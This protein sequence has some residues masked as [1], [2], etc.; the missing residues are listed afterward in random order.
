MIDAT[1]L[2]R[3]TPEDQQIASC[4]VYRLVKELQST[5]NELHGIMIARNDAVIAESWLAPYAANIPH[6]CHSLGKTY[7]CTAVGLACTD[8][9]MS[10]DTFLTDIFADE[11]RSMGLRIHPEMNK[12]RIKDLMS[13]SSGTAGMPRFDELWFRNFLESPMADEPGKH[14]YYNTTGSCMLGAAVEKVTGCSIYSY[15]QERLFKHIGIG[16]SDLVWQR[17]SNGINAEPGIC[18]T[19]EANLRLGLFYLHQGFADGHQIISKEWMQQAASKQIETSATPGINEGSMGY[20]WQ[21][22][23]G[24]VPGLYR[25]DGGQGQLCFVYPRKNCVIAIQQAGR[26]PYGVERCIELC[27][28]FMRDLPERTNSINTDEQNRLVSMLKHRSLPSAPTMSADDIKPEWCGTY[29]V[30]SGSLQP[31]IEVVPVKED[32]WHYF[33]D[34][35]VNPVVQTMSLYVHAPYVDIV[36]NGKS[37]VRARMDGSHDVQQTQNVLPDLES[38]SASAWMEGEKRLV[39]DLR[40]LNGWFRTMMYITFSRSGHIDMVLEKDMLHDQVSPVVYMCEL[41]KNGIR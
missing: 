39:V 26:D 11:I 19:T 41:K 37:R 33:Y 17:F 14:F 15:L 30:T 31:W 16:S 27:H 6:S 5:G 2:R 4:D 35:A 28:S 20:G 9:L 12:V 38:T 32:F 36:F 7:T 1:P 8:G 13:M 23:M 40:W 25:F 22:W 34:P 3:T 24:R 21:L 29:Q 10:P 18:A